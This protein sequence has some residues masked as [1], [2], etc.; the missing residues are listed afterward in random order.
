MVLFDQS[1][2]DS[3]HLKATNEL[4]MEWIEWSGSPQID[5]AE[6]NQDNVEILFKDVKNLPLC[7]TYKV[8]K[9]ESPIGG[10]RDNYIVSWDMT[11]TTTTNTE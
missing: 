6:V 4:L 9:K 8:S 2:G 5:E 1:A 11:T 7:I 10:D 3:I